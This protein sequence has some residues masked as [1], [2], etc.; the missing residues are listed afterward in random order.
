MEIS[1]H[2]LPAEGDELD[3][4]IIEYQK[5]SIHALPAEGDFQ[6]LT[7]VNGF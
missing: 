2:A 1:I 6:I 5:I 7:C 4:E 3:S